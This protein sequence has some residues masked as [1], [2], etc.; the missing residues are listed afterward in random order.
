MNNEKS[1]VNSDASRFPSPL[2]LVVMIEQKSNISE[3]NDKSQK[4]LTH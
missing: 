4:T 2:R 1:E 3:R